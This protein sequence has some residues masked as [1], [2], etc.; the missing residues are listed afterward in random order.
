MQIIQLDL[1]NWFLC[2]RN[3]KETINSFADYILLNS[4]KWNCTAAENIKFQVLS[5]S[6]EFTSAYFWNILI[7]I[8]SNT[9]I[10]ED[11]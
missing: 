1:N 3:L 7:I 5:D 9:I 6:V 10:L 11:V 2:N 8:Q 4:V